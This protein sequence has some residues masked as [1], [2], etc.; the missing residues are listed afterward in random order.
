MGSEI[1]EYDRRFLEALEGERKGQALQ[2]LNDAVNSLLDGV[3]A[4]I[5]TIY[6]LF[7]GHADQA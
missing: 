6:E 4:M 3:F 5:T 2:D 1:Q 7:L